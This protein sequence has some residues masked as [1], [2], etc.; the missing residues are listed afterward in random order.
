MSRDVPAK[1]VDDMHANGFFMKRKYFQIALFGHEENDLLPFDVIQKMAGV[2]EKECAMRFRDKTHFLF[3]REGLFGILFAS[4]SPIDRTYFEERV[5]EILKRFYDEFKIRFSCGNSEAKHF[6]SHDFS[7]SSLYSQAKSALRKS[8]AD[9]KGN[10]TFYQDAKKGTLRFLKLSEN[11]YS[12]LTLSMISGEKGKARS[13]LAK[14]LHKIHRPCLPFYYD[15]ALFQLL[16]HMLE[17]CLSLD[18]FVY[19]YG[20]QTS[21][22][23]SLCAKKGEERVTLFF[24]DILT[25][26]IEINKTICFSTIEK[27][28]HQLVSYARERYFDHS[29]SISSLSKELGYS[30]SYL[31]SAL[32]KHNTTFSKLLTLFRMKEAKRLLS[33]PSNRVMQIAPRL[34]FSLGVA[35]LIVLA[36]TDLSVGRMVGMGGVLTVMFLTTSGIPEISFLGVTPN[37]SSIPMGIRIVLGFLVSVLACSFFSCLVGFFTAKFK[38]HPFISTFANQLMIFGGMV[39]LTG[40]G[41][42]GMPNSDVLKGITGRIGEGTTGFPIMIIYAIILVI[43]MWFIWNKTRFGKNMFAVGGNPEAASGEWHQRLLD[44]DGRLSFGGHSLRHW[45]FHLRH[46]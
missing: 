26:I 33:D 23:E 16:I 19:Q 27:I 20:S 39:L 40:N 36:G 35:G 13:E 14:I 21:L 43:V 45:F 3:E 5:Q 46:L 30:P 9:S 31:F 12:S 44:D 11:D 22:F 17:N 24:E 38:M 32:K 18:D 25:S 4:K 8:I 29:L 37:F 34:F 28:Y 1:F 41:Y 10:V 15:F 42:T 6:P 2:M 7:F